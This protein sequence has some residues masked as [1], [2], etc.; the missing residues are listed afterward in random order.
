[1]KISTKHPGSLGEA[2]ST[3]GPGMSRKKAG[4]REKTPRGESEEIEPTTQQPTI[5]NKK[6]KEVKQPLIPIN[7][8]GGG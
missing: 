7:W 2:N 6:Q 3:Q 1:M 5:N 4:G 8:G